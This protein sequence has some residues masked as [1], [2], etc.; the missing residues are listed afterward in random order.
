VTPFQKRKGA[1]ASDIMFVPIEKA[2]TGLIFKAL[3]T[4]DN[5]RQ[6]TG[7]VCKRR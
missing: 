7:R 4:I 5:L 6:V 3:P 1:D 2:F